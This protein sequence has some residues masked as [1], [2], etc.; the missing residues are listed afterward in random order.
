MK[1][2]RTLRRPDVKM[3]ANMAHSIIIGGFFKPLVNGKANRDMIEDEI[4]I[5]M[6]TKALG[7]LDQP[8]VDIAIQMVDDFLVGH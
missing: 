7:P 6:M 2:T 3:A 5:G 4:T 1:P 8:T